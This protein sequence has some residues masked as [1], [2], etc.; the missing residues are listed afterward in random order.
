MTLASAVWADDQE[1]VPDTSSASASPDKSG[2]TLFNPTPDDEMRKFAPDRP[3]KGFSV[4]TID[5]GHFQLETDFVSY[6]YSNFGGINSR[7][8]QAL[9]PVWKVGLNNWTDLELQFNGVQSSSSFEPSSA[10][11]MRGSGFGDLFLRMKINLVG[12]DDGMVGFAVIPYV[13]LPSATPVISNGVI[14][15]GLIA[16]LA[17]RL[18]KDFLVTLMTEFDALKDAGNSRRYANF[19]N[20][21]GVTH[22]VPGLDD[23]N[24]LVEVFSSVGTDRATPSVYTLDLGL[25]YRIAKNLQLDLGLNIGLN[26]AAPQDQIY[27]GISARF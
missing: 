14:E 19:V 8:V 17:L 9:D 10:L 2:Y 18:P 3:T 11:M 13:K 24:A 4:R 25:T 1:A 23:V 27:T 21:V 7:S 26:K 12:N 15:G 16:P 20:L 5:A 22:P 6:T